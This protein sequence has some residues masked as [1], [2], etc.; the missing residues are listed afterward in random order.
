MANHILDSAYGIDAAIKK[1]QVPLYSE[2]TAKFPYLK[3][4]GYGKTYKNH[5]NGYVPERYK[6]G[7]EYTDIY[8]NDNVDFEFCFIP[9]PKSATEDGIVFVN[10]VK[11]VFVVDLEKL[12]PSYD[13]R[14]DS[15]IQREMV[16][17]LNEVSKNINIKGVETGIDSIYR[18][19]EIGNIIHQ[20]MHPLHTFAVLMEINFYL[21]QKC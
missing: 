9:S 18:G 13:G 15:L 5:R 14:A 3:T 20:D 6:C 1:L 2:I 10:D 21:T 19:Y 12:Y 16:S 8:R 4:E 17:T 7:K 11:C